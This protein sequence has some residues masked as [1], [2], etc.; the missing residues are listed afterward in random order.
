MEKKLR[1]LHCPSA[2]GG[3]AWTLSRAERGLGYQSDNVIFRGSYISYFHDENLNLSYRRPFL[4]SFK[5]LIFFLKAVR[6]YDV[7]HFY[8]GHSMLPFYFDLPILKLLRKKIFFTFQGCDIRRKKY[9]L[10]NFKINACREC[11][12]PGCK[13]KFH[14]FLKILKLKIMVFFANKTFVL[15]PDLKVISPTSEMMPYANVDLNKWTFLPLEEKKEIEVLH[16]PTDRE[17]KGTKYVL[18]AMS[19]LK[20]D[21]YPV[22]LKLVENIPNNEMLDYCKN[23]DI[24][25]DQLS[26]GWYGGFAVEMMA[27]GKPVI[28]YLNEDHLRFVSWADEIPIVNANKDNIH[29]KLKWLINNSERRKNLGRAGRNYVEKYH[30]PLKIAKDMINFY[31]K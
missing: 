20:N 24:V 29:D 11:L 6:K 3:Q 26:V 22:K 30:N 21:G 18:E 2:T 19:K 13:N 27:L 12:S 16:A 31:E 15:N 23:A 28:C 10:A 7:F 9:C 1:I 25:V 8:F 5:V 14:D 17:I 4:S